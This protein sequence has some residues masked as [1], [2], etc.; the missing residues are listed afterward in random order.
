MPGTAEQQQRGD[1]DQGERVAVALQVPDPLDEPQDDDEGGDA[2]GRPQRL[3]AGQVGV[4]AGDGHEPEAVE[5]DGEAEEGAVGPGGEAAD[6]E[7]GHDA[8]AAAPAAKGTR[9]AGSSVPLARAVRTY[10]P[11][12]RITARTTRPSSVDRRA[13]ASGPASTGQAGVEHLHRVGS[14][15]GRGA[16][17]DHGD[18]RVAVVVVVVVA[19]RASR[20]CSRRSRNRSASDRLAKRWPLSRSVRS[21]SVRSAAGQVGLAVDGRLPAEQPAGHALEQRHPVAGQA[22]VVGPPGVPAD[23]ADGE[24]DHGQDGQPPEEQ[25]PHAPA[26]AP[27]AGRPVG[28]R[29][30]AA[31][32]PPR[33][34]RPVRRRRRPRRPVRPPAGDAIAAGGEPA[35][36][37]VAQGVEDDDGDVVVA[38]GLV[39]HVDQRV[40]RLLGV[41]V[42][43]QRLGDG[44]VRQHVGEAVG[45]DQE[46]VAGL[47]GRPGRCRPSTSGVD[48]Q[49]P[50]DD[51]PLRVVLGLLGGE[52]A[53]P[54]QLLDEGVVLGDL[55][56]GPVAHE[57]GAG[58]ADVAEDRPS[59]SC[60]AM[61]VRV[62]PMPRRAALSAAL[63]KT[64]ALAASTAC[65]DA[66]WPAEVGG[67]EG[68]DGGGA[69]HLAGPVAAHP[70]GHGVQ[71]V[72]RVDEEAVLVLRPAPADVGAG[73]RP[74]ILIARSPGRSGRSG[75][76]RRGGAASSCSAGRG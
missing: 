32:R 21:A 74:R 33:R 70:V 39:G 2:D 11:A 43:A 41:G 56:H 36:A 4:E 9:S 42:A 57:V 63:A 67:L 29:V 35:L 64:A 53:L 61:A 28:P 45:A 66:G 16:L 8:S 50:G 44:V 25:G 13:A 22:D 6:G 7:V 62:V 40:G 19:A 15:G 52:A 18:G 72:V 73:A 76:C 1:P 38:A 3:V 58:V 30:R 10:P 51:G 17:G 14:A 31:A 47:G 5:Q 24:A 71:A 60:R 65:V 48:A 34:R 59:P 49:R 37:A 46:A 55:G 54:H 12:A 20:A 23:G 27:A 68:L 75:A 26:G 69:G